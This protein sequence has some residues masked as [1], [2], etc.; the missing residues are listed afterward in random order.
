MRVFMFVRRPTKQKDLAA[1]TTARSK[2]SLLVPTIPE[3]NPKLSTLMLHYNSPPKGLARH[4]L[5]IYTNAKRMS[6]VCVG[7][8]DFSPQLHWRDASGMPLEFSP[9]AFSYLYQHPPIQ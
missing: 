5:A 2:L 6:I 4:L 7:C 9:S 3:T 1:H 8:L